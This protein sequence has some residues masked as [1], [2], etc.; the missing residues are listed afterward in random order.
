MRMTTRAALVAAL[1][2]AALPG[3]AMAEPVGPPDVAGQAAKDALQDVQRTLRTGD[4]D[5]ST[6]LRELARTRGA[7]RDPRDRRTARTFFKRPTDGGAADGDSLVYT[8]DEATPYDVPGGRF[9]VHYVTRGPDA[10]DTTDADDDGVPDYVAQVGAELQKAA[11]KINGAEATGGLAWSDP[12]SDGTRGGGD[13]L[14]DVY[15]G[16]I[17]A[18][19]YV[20]TDDDAEGAHVPAFMVIRRSFDDDVASPGDSR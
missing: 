3:G 10:P 8:T 11:A 12:L 1:T 17:A 2:V 7:L 4:G 18:L 16:K 20:T 6:A 14:V 13:G 15:I 5:A 9:R 19:G